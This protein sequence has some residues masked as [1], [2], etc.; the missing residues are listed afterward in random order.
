MTHAGGARLAHTRGVDD[1]SLFQRLGGADAVDTLV[2]MVHE[3]A[4]GDPE[5]A[6]LLDAAPADETRRADTHRL[7]R[8]LG[9]PEPEGDAGLLGRSD[10]VVAHLR[11]AL[12]LLGVS[13]PLAAE[14]VAAVQ[15]SLSRPEHAP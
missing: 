10:E 2:R 8:V 1:A 13:A 3:R 9:G 12:W 14:I 4:L 11:D 6:L 5:L 15:I 7:T